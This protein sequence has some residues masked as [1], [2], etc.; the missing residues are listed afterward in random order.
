MGKLGR[1]EIAMRA[2]A[3]NCNRCKASPKEI[4]I[5]ASLLFG[6]ALQL[7]PVHISEG[8]PK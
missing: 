8:H 6:C 4:A 5:S 2:N 3:R 7:E 1:F